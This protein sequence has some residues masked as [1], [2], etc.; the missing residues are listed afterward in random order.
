ME[1]DIYPENVELRDFEDADSLRDAIFENVKKE[2]Q[3]AFP[4][5]Y[6]NVRLEISDLYTPDKE[7]FSLKEQKDA[8]LKNK[9]LHR[10]LRGNLKLYDNNTDELI[11]EKKD[12]T[13]MKVPYLTDRSTFIHNGSEYSLI[14][15]SRLKSGIYTRKKANGDLESQI[16][17]ERGHGKAFRVRMEPQ[18]GLFKLDVGQSSL[19]LYSLLRDIGVPDKTLEQKWGSEI[20]EKNKQKYDARVL[21][22]AYERLVPKFSQSSEHS[23][24]EKINLIQ[25]NMKQTKVDAK[26][27]EK[28]LPRLFN[29]S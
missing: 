25:D 10:R 18:S 19:H 11:D 17:P 4:K 6:G 12:H 22:K 5:K 15:Q 16:N 21:N 29:M 26:V 7:R 13:L 20:F 9:Y 27:V 8:I 3:S 2:F 14:N 23:R 1:K 28:T 24:E